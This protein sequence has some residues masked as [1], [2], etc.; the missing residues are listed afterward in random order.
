MTIDSMILFD[1]TTVVDRPSVVCECGHLC[2]MKYENSPL[3]LN[4]WIVILSKVVDHD[5]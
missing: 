1:M 3:R 2:Q 4:D 5:R